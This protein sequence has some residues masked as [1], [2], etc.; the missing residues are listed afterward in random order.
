LQSDPA[1]AH[2]AREALRLLLQFERELSP[3][4]S[5]TREA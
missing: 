3:S 1:Q 4:P 2:T 5:A